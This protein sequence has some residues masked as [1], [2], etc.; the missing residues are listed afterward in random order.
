MRN[1]GVVLLCQILGLASGWGATVPLY[2]NTAPVHVVARPQIAPQIDATAF[3]NQSEFEVND[4]YFTGLPYQT[5]NTRFFTNSARAYMSG[6]LGFRVEYSSGNIRLPMHTFIN[7]GSITGRT[8]LLI[9]ATNITS[10]G[11]LVAS[12]AG[13]IRIAGKNVNLRGN[14]IQASPLLSS[15][16]ISGSGSSSNYV[17]PTGVSDRYWALGTNNT[18]NGQGGLMPLANSG[19][20]GPIFDLTSPLSPQ[21][22]ILESGS[23][24]PFSQQIYMGSSNAGAFAYT[25]TLSATSSVV[26]V[27]FV[28]TNSIFDSNIS[29]RVSFSP[30][31]DGGADA[32]VELSYPEFDIV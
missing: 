30:D 7:Q 17:N 28:P 2:V 15:F 9:S 18:I 6:D 22:Q 25:T 12:E 8:Y 27:V 14:G 1:F 10:T 32:I 3:A 11:P 19:F 29:V 20:V 13:L 23:P 16:V 21:H 4:I 26:Q 31:G 24:Q 5:F